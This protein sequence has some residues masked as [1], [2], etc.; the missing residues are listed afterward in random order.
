MIPKDQAERKQWIVGTAALIVG[1]LLAGTSIAI[2]I[3][4]GSVYRLVGALYLFGFISLCAA[5]IGAIALYNAKKSADKRRALAQKGSVLKAEVTSFAEDFTEIV[6]GQAAYV[7]KCTATLP[8]GEERNFCSRPLG[9]D[10]GPHVEEGIVRVVYLPEDP[11]NY[12][13][14]V[15]GIFGADEEKEDA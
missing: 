13:V 6:N 12:Y 1:T 14:D 15:L 9:Y 8:S 7:L 4:S 2:G 10:P 11:A 3:T 5:V